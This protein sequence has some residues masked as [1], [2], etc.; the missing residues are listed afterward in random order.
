VEFRYPG[1]NATPEDVQ[2]ALDKTVKIRRFLI[3]KIV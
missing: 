3:P 2:D 1:E